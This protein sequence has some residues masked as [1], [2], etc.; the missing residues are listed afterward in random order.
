MIVK[1]CLK[2]IFALSLLEGGL[3]DSKWN[4]AIEGDILTHPHHAF[5]EL[6]FVIARLAFCEREDEDYLALSELMIVKLLARKIDKIGRWQRLIQNG[7][8]QN[9]R[10]L[11][12][13]SLRSFIKEPKA[14]AENENE[15]QQT[16]K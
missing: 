13:T 16:A 9:Q 11:R 2:G 1:V 15:D 14:N 8:R 4:Y 12:Q 3:S 10:L 7:R 6:V 5:K